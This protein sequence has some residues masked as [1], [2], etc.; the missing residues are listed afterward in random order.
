MKKGLAEPF[1]LALN[2]ADIPHDPA[3]ALSRRPEDF[4]YAWERT[5]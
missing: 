4:D 1:S 3:E 2:V 5:Q